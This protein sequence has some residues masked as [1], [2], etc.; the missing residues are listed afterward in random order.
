MGGFK[1]IQFFKGRSSPLMKN[2]NIPTLTCPRSPRCRHHH[3]FLVRELGSE[4][5]WPHSWFPT[6]QILIGMVAK[7]PRE[8][9]AAPG[10]GEQYLSKTVPLP[11]ERWH[12][13]G[14]GKWKFH[15]WVELRFKICNYIFKWH[16]DENM[17]KCK[18]CHA[19]NYWDFTWFMGAKPTV[20]EISTYKVSELAFYVFTH[21]YQKKNP[22]GL[23]QTSCPRLHWK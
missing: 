2:L 13:S 16:E 14:G 4:A 7:L 10:S 9:A 18:Q 22:R 8:R 19:S 15:F 12:Q 21:M 6:M 17:W 20:L 1:N 5:F 11:P 23:D 3:P